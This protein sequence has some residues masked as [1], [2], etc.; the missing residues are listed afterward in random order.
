MKGADLIGRVWI[1]FEFKHEYYTIPKYGV[2]FI[3]IKFL[4]FNS[5]K[6]F[7][8]KIRFSQNLQ[9]INKYQLSILLL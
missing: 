9:F 6:Y 5:F 2:N 4:I 1:P 8:T 3:Y 7:I